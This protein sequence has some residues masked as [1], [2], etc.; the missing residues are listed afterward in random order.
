MANRQLPSVKTLCARLRC[1]STIAGAI[2]HVLNQDPRTDA[3]INDTLQTVSV[4]LHGFG[5]EYLPSKRDTHGRGVGLEYVNMGE[6]YAA[7]ILYDC[8]RRRFLCAAW[9]DMVEARPGR[10]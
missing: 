7:T 2:R 8:L 10:F 6:T 3:E 4:L 1:D 9:G 5:V